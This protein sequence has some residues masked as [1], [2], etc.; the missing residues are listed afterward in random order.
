MKKG[1]LSSILALVATVALLWINPA[2]VTGQEPPAG[3]KGGGKGGFGGKGKGGP[4]P[5]PA[6]PFTRLPDGHPDMQGYWNG[7]FANAVTDIQ[8]KGRSAIIEPAD[9]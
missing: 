7:Q 3:G 8:A 6:G 9:G 5:P 4:P 1:Y 2:L